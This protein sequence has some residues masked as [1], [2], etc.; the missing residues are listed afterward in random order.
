M[1]WGLHSLIYNEIFSSLVDVGS[2]TT[3]N[4]TNWMYYINCILLKDLTITSVDVAYFA[5]EAIE[6]Q[7]KRDWL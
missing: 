3:C 4:P 2:P 1:G 6:Y 7:N 5:W